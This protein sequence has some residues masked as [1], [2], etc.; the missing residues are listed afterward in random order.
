MLVCGAPEH[1]AVDVSEMG[2]RIVE[3]FDPAVEHNGKIGPCLLQP[4]GPPV[5]ERWHLTVLFR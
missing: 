5:V 3:P 1:D 2:F 4:I